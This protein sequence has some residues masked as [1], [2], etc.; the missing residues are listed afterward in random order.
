MEMHQR[1]FFHTVIMLKH[2]IL[3]ILARLSYSAI[4][5]H[6]KNGKMMLPA[7]TTIIPRSTHKCQILCLILN[8]HRFSLHIFLSFPISNFI[9]IDPVGDEMIC[10]DTQEE[11]FWAGNDL[12]H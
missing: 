11:V 4:P 3:L 2:F 10:A 12:Q 7:T 9:K 1:I 8:K 6:L 5:F